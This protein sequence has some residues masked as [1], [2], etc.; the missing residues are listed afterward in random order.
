M[1]EHLP[2]EKGRII[3]NS[4]ITHPKKFI[5]LPLYAARIIFYLIHVHTVAEEVS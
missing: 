2:Q 3:L 4:E 5:S 1:T